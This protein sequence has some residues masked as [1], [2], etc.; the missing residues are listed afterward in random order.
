MSYK[1][2]RGFAFNGKAFNIGDSVSPESIGKDNFQDRVADGSLVPDTAP[3]YE[4]EPSKPFPP[5]PQPELKSF[6][7]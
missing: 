7:K 1:I 5:Q 3:K 2:V 4:K 6:P